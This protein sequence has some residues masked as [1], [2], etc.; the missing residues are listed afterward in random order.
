MDG[1]RRQF[2]HFQK[3]KTRGVDEV[4]ES[5]S[6]ITWLPA[7][8][9][10]KFHLVLS[11]SHARATSRQFQVMITFHLQREILLQMDRSIGLGAWHGSSPRTHPHSPDSHLHSGFPN[12]GD[13]SP[14][15]GMLGWMDVG[16]GPSVTLTRSKT[17]HKGDRASQ[18][19]ASEH[20]WCCNSLAQ[21]PSLLQP[22]YR[23]CPGLQRF[24]IPSFAFMTDN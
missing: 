11:W 19:P 15:E 9:A 13:A 16:R 7:L 2:S 20:R 18:L 5:C 24:N 22:S 21:E 23:I 8:K 14:Q 12:D 6:N 1:Y 4:S 3:N 10:Q 17:T